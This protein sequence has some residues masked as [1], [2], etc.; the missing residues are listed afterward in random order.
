MPEVNIES[1]EID[2]EPL[3]DTT[4]FS[5][6]ENIPVE[7][8]NFEFEQ[9]GKLHG[10]Y[11]K[12]T[13]FNDTHCY[14]SIK[15]KHQRKHK[16]R[17]DIAYL[18]P[19][20]FRTRVVAWNW[21]YASLALIGLDIVL[22]F[23]GWLDTSSVNFL[24]LFLGVLV[25]AVICLLAFFYYS[26]DKVFFRSQYGKIKLVELIN[27]SPDSDSFRS[28][29]TKF[30]MQIKK[31]KTAKNINQHKFLTR[32]LQELRRLK[33]ETVIPIDSYEKAKKLIFKHEAFSSAE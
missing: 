26:R 21:L 8:I 33:D 4:N 9:T 5:D 11:R 13:I 16:Y 31:S 28:F 25:V 7:H 22:I 1:A 24:G 3:D 2:L 14:Q 17:I 19:R 15:D 6:N 30:V 20:P 32:E 18:D 23:A 12:L 29:I 10:N 27:K